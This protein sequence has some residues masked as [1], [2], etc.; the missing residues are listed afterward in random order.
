MQA[1]ECLGAEQYLSVK[2]HDEVFTT[3]GPPSNGFSIVAKKSGGS[4]C[5]AVGPVD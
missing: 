5:L 1:D 2:F 4:R 3:S